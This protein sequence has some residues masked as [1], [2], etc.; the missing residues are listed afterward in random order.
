MPGPDDNIDEESKI[1]ESI[2]L[3][4]EI[5]RVLNDG[6]VK[7]NYK[8]DARNCYL[9]VHLENDEV[10]KETLSDA[11]KRFV[12]EGR[13]NNP[14]IEQNPDRDDQYAKV[15]LIKAIQEGRFFVPDMENS[16]IYNIGIENDGSGRL[17]LNS[18]EKPYN[19]EPP[20]EP[21]FLKRLFHRIGFFKEDFEEYD[22]KMAEYDNFQKDK[23]R[24]SEYNEMEASN[25]KRAKENREREPIE[26]AERKAYR[27]KFAVIDSML[28]SRLAEAEKIKKIPDAERTPEQK[29]TLSALDGRSLKD[30]VRVK[31]DALAKSDPTRITRVCMLKEA[32]G[33]ELDHGMINQFGDAEMLADAIPVEGVPTKEEV[34][35][36]YSAVKKLNGGVDNLT[37]EESKY[38]KGLCRDNIGI[39][40]TGLEKLGIGDSTGIDR[41]TKNITDITLACDRDRM[42]A[43]VTSHIA[44]GMEDPDKGDFAEI[45]A[46]MARAGGI[47]NFYSDVHSLDGTKQ[48]PVTVSDGIRSRLAVSTPRIFSERERNESEINSTLENLSAERVEPAY[49]KLQKGAG[50]LSADEGRR[51]AAEVAVSSMGKWPDGVNP[52]DVSEKLA[53]NEDFQKLVGTDV[54]KMAEMAK[55]GSLVKSTAEIFNQGGVPKQ[56][57]MQPQQPQIQKAAELSPPPAM[58]R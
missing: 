33:G 52:R 27:E 39:L 34:K 11:I 17:T 8:K 10:H 20:E 55:N 58:G 1:E 44:L 31:Q 5:E 21:S 13:E 38:L 57:E 29:M 25:L 36:F 42:R 22:R 9:L 51:L 56:P 32:A 49:Q 19:I 26:A 53:A 18:D 30:D 6:G 40:N 54:S 2:N 4:T 12:K 50:T 28:E 37:P 3:R 46:L 15:G 7:F 41:D 47:G 43:I 45:T 23:I 35:T 48:A 24:Y 16:K 14:G